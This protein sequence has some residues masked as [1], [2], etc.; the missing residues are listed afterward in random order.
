ME[1][2]GRQKYLYRA[3]DQ[4]G[5]VI[6]VMLSD[7]REYPSGQEVLPT[8]SAARRSACRDHHRQGSHPSLSPA[9]VTGPSTRR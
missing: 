8:C 4:F 7:T 6:D 3:V 2:A 1:V 9:A 5:Q